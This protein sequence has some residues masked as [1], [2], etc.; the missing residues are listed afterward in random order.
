MTETNIYLLKGN[1][2]N[3]RKRC[4]LYSKLIINTMERFHWSL[5]GVFIGNFEHI[6]D[7]YLVLLLL[8]LNKYMFCWDDFFEHS[9]ITRQMVSLRLSR[10]H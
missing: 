3:I 6:L 10:R 7:L 1:N 9:V 2:R 4:E 8:T 5:S